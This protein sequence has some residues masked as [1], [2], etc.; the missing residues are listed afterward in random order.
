MMHLSSYRIHH[1]SVQL[2]SMIPEDRMMLMNFAL[3]CGRLI[4]QFDLD[5]I[6][7]DTTTRCSK[8]HVT[9]AVIGQ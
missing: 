6:R 3:C 9:Y 1:V 5:L 8:A 2:E 7:I 4:E